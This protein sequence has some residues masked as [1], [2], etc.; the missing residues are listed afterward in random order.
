MAPFPDGHFYSPVVDPKLLQHRE[1]EIWPLPPPEI[2]GINFN[3]D[4]Q[5]SLMEKDF[6][7]F[8]ESFSYPEFEKDTQTA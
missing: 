7:L 1:S 6:P 4:F 2:Q 5:K 3:E 8:L